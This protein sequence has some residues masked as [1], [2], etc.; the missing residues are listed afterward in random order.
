M[1]EVPIGG[2]TG[3][4]HET[5]ASIDEAANWLA[6]ETPP[7]H[8]IVPALRKR[9]GLTPIEACQALREADAIRRRTL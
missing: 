6:G 7:P 3:L 4:D 1:T 9:F 5:S 8:P 2:S